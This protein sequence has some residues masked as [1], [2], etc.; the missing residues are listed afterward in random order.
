METLGF[1]PAEIDLF[2]DLWQELSDPARYAAW[3]R[4]LDDE[5]QEQLRL[6]REQRSTELARTILTPYFDGIAQRFNFRGAPDWFARVQA[7]LGRN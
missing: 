3:N 6:M 5:D 1:T 7:R 4:E 2:F